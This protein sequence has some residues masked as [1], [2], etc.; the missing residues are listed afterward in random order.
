MVV[1]QA[2]AHHGDNLTPLDKQGAYLQAALH[3]E[4]ACGTTGLSQWHS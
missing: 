2:Y 1:Q 3:G 4:L